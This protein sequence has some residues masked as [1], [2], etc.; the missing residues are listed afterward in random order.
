[1]MAKNVQPIKQNQFI[2]KSL[3]R[4][5]TQDR[6]VENELERNRMREFSA[7]IADSIMYKMKQQAHIK[8]MEERRK[9]IESMKQVRRKQLVHDQ[10][11][12]VRDVAGGKGKQKARVA[13]QVQLQVV[14]DAL[15]TRN[16]VTLNDVEQCRDGLDLKMLYVKR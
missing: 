4:L 14:K 3:R 9:T 16:T 2:Q 1:M 6:A 11:Q 5:T 13:P 12:E 10:S 15:S 7:S 8:G